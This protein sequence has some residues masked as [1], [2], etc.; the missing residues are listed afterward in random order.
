MA[1]PSLLI[2]DDNPVNLL[3]LRL[4]LVRAGY[5]PLEASDGIEAVTLATAE[6][7]DLILIDIM[8]PRMNGIAAARRILEQ[9]SG[10][11][12]KLIAV[13]GNTEERLTDECLAAGISTVLHK[14]ID[15]RELIETIE[16]L[17]TIPGPAGGSLSDVDAA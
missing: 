14:P 6:K 5:A 9:A 10:T 4:M 13:T 12:P 16:R 8:M 11:A 15:A 17:T 7:P 2:V 3:V 1:K